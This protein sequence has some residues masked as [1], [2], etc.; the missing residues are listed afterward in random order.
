MLVA[1]PTALRVGTGNVITTP[2]QTMHGGQALVL[3]ENIVPFKKTTAFV[4]VHADSTLFVGTANGVDVDDYLADTTYQLISNVD[5][6][7][8]MTHR[9]VS[10]SSALGA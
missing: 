3:D 1:V 10:G 7:G 6:P 4:H 9:K 2:T 5:F 8:R